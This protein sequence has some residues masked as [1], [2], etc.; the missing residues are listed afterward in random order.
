MSSPKPERDI[1]YLASW[2]CGIYPLGFLGALDLFFRGGRRMAF[3]ALLCA[4]VVFAAQLLTF[5]F[6]AGSG[7]DGFMLGAWLILP[8]ATLYFLQTLDWPAP[9]PLKR[10]F[11]VSVI[12]ILAV[13]GILADIAITAYSD[14]T[15]RTYVDLAIDDANKA[16]ESVADYFYQ[17][18]RFPDDLEQTGLRMSA[19]KFI[20][21]MYVSDKGSVKL[22]MAFAPLRG[23]S[24]AFVPMMD[25]NRIIWRCMSR[26]IED[27]YLPVTCRS[28]NGG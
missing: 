11:W 19:S 13:V 4:L 15:T 27:K 18:R 22:V 12:I 25:G 28:K 26:E 8:P 17:H 10:G 9:A 23:K 3:Q 2:L 14:M 24:L 7:S 21:S 1:S 5:A 16:T 6:P 20:T